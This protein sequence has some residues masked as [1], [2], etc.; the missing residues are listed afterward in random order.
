LDTAFRYLLSQPGVNG[1]TVGVG[2]AGLLGVDNSVETARRHTA[3]VKSLVLLSG[4]TLR[5][6]LRFLHESSELPRVVRCV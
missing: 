1:D 3:E 5:P 6:Q 4:E 2:G